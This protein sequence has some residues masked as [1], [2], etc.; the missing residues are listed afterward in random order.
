MQYRSRRDRSTAD[1]I[2]LIRRALPY[3]GSTKNQLH[4]VLL[5]WVKTF[6]KVDGEA[7]LRS[8][9]IIGVGPKLARLVISLYRN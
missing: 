8:V 5:D 6:N 2:H 1:T 7:I 4:L 9:E 3:G